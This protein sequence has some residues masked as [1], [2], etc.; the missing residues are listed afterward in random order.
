MAASRRRE[1]LA[2]SWE[3]IG[4]LIQQET[5]RNLKNK[6]IEN[7]AGFQVLLVK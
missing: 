6:A 7:A 5:G 3:G 4:G 2:W 1:D